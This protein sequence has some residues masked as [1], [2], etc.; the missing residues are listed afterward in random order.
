MLKFMSNSYISL[1][2]LFKSY[3]GKNTV[4][5]TI[6]ITFTYISSRLENYMTHD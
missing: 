5:S 3:H 2:E 1:D 6:S 4:S